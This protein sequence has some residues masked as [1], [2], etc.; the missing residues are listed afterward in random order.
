MNSALHP[1]LA[2]VLLAGLL[3]SPVRGQDKPDPAPPAPPAVEAP[4]ATPEKPAAP[5]EPEAEQ[6]P[7]PSKAKSKSKKKV[8]HSETTRSNGSFVHVETDDQNNRVSVGTSVHLKA[9]ET[10]NDLVVVF[11]DAT[12][13]GAVDGDLVVVMGN[14][15]VNGT[16][17]GDAVN[18]GGG[19]FLGPKSIVN[20]DAVGVLGGVEKEEGAVVHGKVIPVGL[21]GFNHFNAEFLQRWFVECVLLMRPL[22]LH[23]A[24]VWWIW[25]GFIGFYLLLTVLVPR[26][27][28]ATADVYAE[29]TASSFLLGIAF[30]ALVPIIALILSLTVIGTPFFLAAVVAGE[31]VGKAALLLQLGRLVGRASHLRFPPLVAVLAGSVLMTLL[32]LTPFLGMLV[33]TVTNFWALGAATL[34]LTARFRKESPKPGNNPGR[35]PFTP[36]PGG[37]SNGGGGSG[38]SPS[39]MSPV[40]PS[41]ASSAYAS[42][43]TL[44]TSGIV[45][46]AAVAAAAAAS[47]T[48]PAPALLAVTTPESVQSEP[49]APPAE[50]ASIPPANAPGADTT[51]APLVEVEGIK[52]SNQESTPASTTAS[53]AAPAP[54]DPLASRFTTT[55]PPFNLG[56][57]RSS[58]PTG[59][60]FRSNP[61]DSDPLALPRAGF[62]LRLAAS[63]C[64]WI[65]LLIL[66][67]ETFIHRLPGFLRFAI[68][69]AY[70]AGFY[71]WKGASLGG[72]VLGLQ[73]VRVDGRPM[74][75]ACAI[76]R[77]LSSVFSAVIGGIGYLWCIWDKDQQTWH[78]KLAGTVLVKR[79]KIQPLV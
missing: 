28:E 76:V 8:R 21:P 51:P 72:L 54:E 60:E 18:V 75:A 67:E 35:P 45:T 56:S 19:L 50:P 37:G 33:N 61:L 9:G 69:G 24:W 22:S 2:L 65:L 39:P 30:V 3:L 27:V 7:S 13:D 47:T 68:Y 59:S 77:A 46:G 44:S 55:P 20:G 49:V 70:F 34:A 10:A 32:Y 78:D 64:D 52:P 38:P 79:N 5:A 6:T 71:M 15:H 53:A 73:V 48:S 4:T 31:I 12:V 63:L 42:S 14:T 58:G 16:V 26:A 1:L 41:G 25:A 74:D 23:V 57:S 66:K 29:R 17:K 40:A 43:S 62:G 36:P 11:G